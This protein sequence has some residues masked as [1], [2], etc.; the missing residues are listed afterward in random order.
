MILLNVVLGTGVFIFILIV[1]CTIA[2]V[3]GAV[4]MASGQNNKEAEEQ[5]KKN[6]KVI[7]IDKSLTQSYRYPWRPEKV[8]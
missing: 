7:D 8:N 1:C 5:A 4:W 2:F 3:L 6:S